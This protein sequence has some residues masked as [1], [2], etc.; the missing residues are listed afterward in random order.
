MRPEEDLKRLLNGAFSV[1]GLVTGDKRDTVSLKYLQVV[2]S[3]FGYNFPV[4]IH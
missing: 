2:D 4:A 3:G 1:F